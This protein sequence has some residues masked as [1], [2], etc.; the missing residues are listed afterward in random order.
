MYVSQNHSFNENPKVEWTNSM[1]GIQNSQLIQKLTYPYI[2]KPGRCLYHYLL[3][4]RL[5]V[6][7]CCRDLQIP[8]IN[9]GHGNQHFGRKWKTTAVQKYNFLYE[10]FSLVI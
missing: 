4:L 5:A 3:L 1:I 2:Q 6:W 9:T 7:W 10:K 8:G